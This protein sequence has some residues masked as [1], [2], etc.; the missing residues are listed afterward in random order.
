MAWADFVEVNVTRQLDAV[1]SGAGSIVYSGNPQ[2][3]NKTVT[4]IG[5]IRPGS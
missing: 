4:G 1:V 5:S 3:V 2:I